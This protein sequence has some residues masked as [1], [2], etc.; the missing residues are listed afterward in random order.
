MIDPTS[1][2]CLLSFQIPEKKLRWDY[3]PSPCFAC[4]D[5]LPDSIEFDTSQK[6]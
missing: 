4:I 6:L 1:S 2:D 3:H 5:S